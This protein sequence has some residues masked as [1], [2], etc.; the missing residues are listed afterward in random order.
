MR[1][2]AVVAVAAVLIGH[3]P[4]W[5]QPAQGFTAED[6]AVIARNEM[7]GALRGVDP[8]G[9]RI[10][11]DALAKARAHPEGNRNRK[12][13]DVTQGGQESPGP[14][15]SARNPDLGIYFQRAS[16]EAAYDLF[17]ILKRVGATSSG[18]RK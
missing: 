12:K 2:I 14:V 11:L 15:D 13:R 3:G 1:T 6:E 16:P 17:Q 5:T 4:A 9:T 18:T 10:V 7:L 8:E